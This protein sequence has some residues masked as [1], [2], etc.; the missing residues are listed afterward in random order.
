MAEH[1][2]LEQRLGQRRAVDRDQGT[3]AAA[4]VVVNELRDQLLSRAALAR[5]ENR[6]IRRSYSV[7]QLHHLAERGRCAQHGDLVADAMSP[8]LPRPQVALVSGNQDGVTGPSHQ[9]L[10]L[11]P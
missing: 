10:Q 8:A 9:N 2:R 4:A 3:S 11:C 6:R 7:R 1:L 5:D